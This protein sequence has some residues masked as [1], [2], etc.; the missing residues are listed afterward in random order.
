MR[1]GSDSLIDF[2]PQFMRS[3]SSRQTSVSSK[4]SDP[5]RSLDRPYSNDDVKDVGGEDEDDPWSFG[6]TVFL[7]VNTMIGAG[8]LN[9]PQVFAKAG[10]G[11]GFGMF[12]G[13][14]WATWAGLVLLVRAGEE[15]GTMD[16]GALAE[17]LF[18]SRMKSATDVLIA[19]SGFGSLIGYF[20]A[21]GSLASSLAQ[22]FFGENA[23]TAYEFVLP[24]LTV[25]IFPL[26]LV[27][28]FGHLAWICMFSVTSIAFVTL[29]V[30]LR[31]PTVGQQLGQRPISIHWDV[32]AG[33]GKFGAISFALGSAH[34]AFHAHHSLRES[35]HGRW[36]SVSCVAVVVGA[37]LCTAI[38]V[39]GY[40][41]FGDS[42]D[43]NILNNFP[44][45]SSPIASAMK[46]MVTIHLM[47]YIPIDFIIMR[48][49]LA[50]VFGT[51]V[52]ELPTW[53]YL[54]LNVCLV[55][56]CLAITL[57]TQ[58]FGVILDLT[59]GV[60]GSFIY[61]ILPSLMA[62]K[63]LGA[64]WMGN[65]VLLFGFLALVATLVGVVLRT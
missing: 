55:A 17:E 18:G 20:I 52:L 61:F 34:S 27:R 7:L 48:H 23:F 11:L 1:E 31:G 35:D 15:T 9:M 65:I 30:L 10:L 54:V 49:S 4:D 39:S 56:V 42:T 2:E 19:V 26:T 58:E 37:V 32:L 12:A 59:G 62:R 3:N 6:K 57:K 44:S 25:L 33:L 50:L 5:H 13:T 45:A 16:Y 22:Q 47:L 38:G 29:M 14:A 24:V 53:K 36:G 41:S 64:S 60:A 28:E 8:I 21:I 51:D 46:V 63:A 43:A 40:L